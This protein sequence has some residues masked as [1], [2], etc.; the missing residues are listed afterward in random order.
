MSACLGVERD[1]LASLALVRLPLY[2]YEDLRRL[3]FTRRKE[4][5]CTSRDLDL[6]MV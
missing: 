4:D 5:P 1:N 6:R 3:Q 2:D